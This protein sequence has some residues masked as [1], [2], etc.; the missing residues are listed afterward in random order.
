MKNYEF[1]KKALECYENEKDLVFN[2]MK[3]YCLLKMYKISYV[4]FNEKCDEIRKKMLKL[5]QEAFGNKHNDFAEILLNDIL[6][7]YTSD[8][9]NDNMMFN[10]QKHGDNSVFGNPNDNCKHY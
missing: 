9:D 3:Y 6:E 5:I 4:F 1:V 7:L 2:I 8:D 10:M